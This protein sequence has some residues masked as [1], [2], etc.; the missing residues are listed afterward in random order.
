MVILTTVITSSGSLVD[1]DATLFIQLGIFLVML[2]LLNRLIF[3][4]VIALIEARRE[5]TE[6]AMTAARALDNEAAAL[7]ASLSEKLETT[8]KS[9][10][11]K[12]DALLQAATDQERMI[13]GHA[14]EEAHAKVADMKRRAISDLSFTRATLIAETA[15]LVTK[16]TTKMLN[17]AAEH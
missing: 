7:D 15:T 2:F 1:V 10:I 17:R 3:K 4:P 11:E 14:R 6:G 12:R 9:A 13:I 5:A 16:V 8:R